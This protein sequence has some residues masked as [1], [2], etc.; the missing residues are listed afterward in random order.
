[1]ET[2]KKIKDL[3]EFERPGEWLADENKRHVAFSI[4][5]S[6]FS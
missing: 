2:K 1:M 4:L 3:P 6:N 5:K